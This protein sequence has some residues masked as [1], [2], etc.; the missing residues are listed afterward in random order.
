MVKLK[1]VLTTHYPIIGILL[2]SLLITAYL[3]TYTNWDAQ[4]E[5]EATSSILTQGFPYISTGFMINQ[6]PLGFYVSA[7]FFGVGGLSYLNGVLLTTAFGLGSV[8]LLYVL[9]NLMYGRKT[10]L[11]AAAL[12]GMMPW[13]VYMSRVFLIDNQYLFWG[14][15]FLILGILAVRRNS[16]KLVLGTGVVFAVALLTKLY[17]VFMLIPMLLV[18]YLHRKETCFKLDFKKVILFVLPSLVLHVVW[19]GIFANQHFMGVYFNTDF[20]HPEW[21]ADPVLAFLPII[22][23]NSAGWFVFLGGFFSLAL[24]VIYRK[25]LRAFLK[26]DVVCL[27]TIGVIVGLNLFLVLGLHLMIPYVSAF[28]YNYS[29]VPFFCLLAASLID[30]SGVLIESINQ[31]KDRLIAMGLGVVG[32]GLLF[33]S[34]I[35]STLFLNYRWGFVPFGVDSVTYYGLFVFSEAMDRNLLEMLHFGVLILVALCMVLPSLITVLKKQFR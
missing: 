27:G 19:F 34:L 22:F 10:G 23:V 15:L 16:Q 7:L 13:H 35:E 6:P 26:M 4:I 33:A 28:K 3:A 14:L 9:G 30:K 25:R 18:I 17:A 2:G 8:F 29:V 31:K 21:V 11:A 12:F 5:Y 24:G 32:L 20:T 1:A